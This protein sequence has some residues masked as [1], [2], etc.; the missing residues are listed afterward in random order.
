MEE[1][2]SQ[3]TI[4]KESEVSKLQTTIRE[5]L[6]TLTEMK[7]GTQQGISKDLKW[8]RLREREVNRYMDLRVNNPSLPSIEELRLP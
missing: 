5:G 2:V 6:P 3:E 4:S 1:T 7:G 8:R